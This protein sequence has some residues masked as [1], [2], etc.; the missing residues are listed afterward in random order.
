VRRPLVACVLLFAVYVGL[1]FA[2]N[3][4]G[5]L[6]TDTGGKVATLRTMESRGGLNPD[7]GYWA[8]RWDPGGDLHPLFYTSHIAGKWVN[9]TTVPVLYLAEPLYRA[10]GYRL[11][12]ALPMLGSVAAALA[13]YV[14][15]RRLGA[16]GW[17]AFAVVGLLSPLT[18]YALDF[19]EHSIGVAL[20]AWAVIL[21]I[22]AMG[23]ARPWPRAL[24]AGLLFGAAAT[25]RTEALVYAAVTTAAVCLLVLVRHRRLG[26]P[27]LMG[28]A[29]VAGLVL[30]LAGNVA[31]ERAT[32]GGTIRSA[33]TSGTAAEAGRG[34]RLRLE[35]GLITGVG[36]Q[37]E[38]SWTSSAVG[39]ALLLL[40]VFSVRA[41][42]RGGDPG[43]AIVGGLGAVGLYAVR[44]SQGLG[45]IPGMTAASPVAA[46][47]LADGWSTTNRRLLVG[48]ALCALP[49][50]WAFQFLGGAYAQWGGRYV[51]MSGFLLA[52]VGA[53]ALE[54]ARRQ[55]AAAALALAAGVA[56]F[57]LVWLSSRSHDVAR[58][59]AV[60]YRRSDPV[61]IS[62]IAHLAREGGAYYRFGGHPWLTAVTDSEEQAA[63]DLV[64]RAGLPGFAVVDDGKATVST[65]PGFTPTGTEHVEFLGL[66][67]RISTYR[68]DNSGHG[69]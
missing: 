22:D 57:G 54:R 11:A 51:L 35:E 69:G 44:F 67:L 14:L 41:V 23:A 48:V 8:A 56:A 68:A 34:A 38:V 26:R 64:R 1:S 47:G 52:V 37:P 20:M 66:R 58:A 5:T 17:L 32:I 18:I 6:G 50:V 31:L 60:L 25:L 65:L 2:N 15:A 19:W 45:F 4:H 30:P 21:L 62:R 59:E 10:G 53:T 63:V 12:I 61:L 29:I 24:G 9:V 33:R 36:L 27:M 7:V 46:V 13:A 28:V 40:V 42:K 39:G 16:K 49:I 55:A 43:P 3:T